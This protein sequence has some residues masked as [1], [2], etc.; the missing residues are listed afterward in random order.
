M[1]E[2]VTKMTVKIPNNYRLICITSVNSVGS[3]YTD[4]PT[5]N[6]KWLGNHSGFNFGKYV[7]STQQIKN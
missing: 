3:I 6:T 5:V 2:I 7:N 4:F 1:S